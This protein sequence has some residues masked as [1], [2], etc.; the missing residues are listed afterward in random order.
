MPG[1]PG[2]AAHLIHKLFLRFV[3][4]DEHSLAGVRPDLGEATPV[5]DDDAAVLYHLP[6]RVGVLLHAEQHRQRGVVDDGGLV[7]LASLPA[8]EVP[9]VKR[10]IRGRFG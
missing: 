6:Q 5:V 2:F 4:V 9:R 3:E 8:R 1:P 10:D 7:P